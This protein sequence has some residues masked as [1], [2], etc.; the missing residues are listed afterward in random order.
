M[1]KSTVDSITPMLT[2]LFDL[3]I[4]S[5]KIPNEWKMGRIAPVPIT[6]IAETLIITTALKNSDLWGNPIGDKGLHCT[7]VP[8]RSPDN[9]IKNSLV[10]LDLYQCYMIKGEWSTIC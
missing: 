3:S 5:G 2:A 4:S 7:S 10:T 6:Y 1:L 9:N 8:N